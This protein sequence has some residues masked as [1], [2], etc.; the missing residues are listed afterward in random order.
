MKNKIK[1]QK[2]ETDLGQV[3]KSNFIIPEGC[4]KLASLRSFAKKNVNYNFKNII[5]IISDKTTLI[6]AYELIKSN[7]GNSTRGVAKNTLD[8]ISSEWFENTSKALLAGKY[9]FN[10]SRRKLITKPND[11]SSKRPL[12][13]A[14]PREKVV[15]KAVQMVLEAI[16]EPTFL[17]ESHGFRPN[18]GNHTALYHIK[19]QFKSVNWVIEADISKCFDTINHNK[20][21]DVIKERIS[22]DKTIALIKSAL[23]AGFIEGKQFSETT[24]GIPQGSI[25]SPILC[26]IFLHQLDRFIAK[27]SQEFDEGG[28]K[29]PR[30]NEKRRLKYQLD[31]TAKPKE[32]KKY[33]KQLMELKSSL[34]SNYKK[35]KYVR[36]ADDF[37]V[38]I[39]GKY[40]DANNMREE[41]NKYLEDISLTLN[42]QKTKITKFSSN[43]VFFLETF[44]RGTYRKNKPM[45]TISRGNSK[46]KTQITPQVSFH[47]PI[48]KLLGKLTEKGYFKRKG[49]RTVPKNFGAL[50][51]LNHSDILNRYNQIIK[52]ILNYYSFVDNFKSIG[53][54]IHRLKMSCALTLALKYKVRT[55]AKIFKKFGKKLGD[56]QTEIEL[57]IPKT[58]KR[59]Q[60]FKIN[61]VNPEK[62]IIRKWNN[63]LTNSNL[64]KACIICDDKKN[65][66]MRH[67]K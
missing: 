63:K 33:I 47:A 11:P 3:N 19:T 55:A 10:P 12:D 57:F 53:T 16:F 52:G 15:Q 31:K 61:Q 56:K 48:K 51:N 8:G 2:R 65:V 18:R 13:I 36:Y 32:R 1:I 7:P 5:H 14:N 21:L 62:I 67:V 45:K 38:G 66:E 44:I 49:N 58:F 40:I 22:C 43:K 50:V 30:N 24:L 35:L 34:N 46:F 6:L 54:I 59:S 4:E 9:K 42:L 28:T 25:I 17:N 64:G 20:L 23:K 29:R 39:A 26:N 27:K 41:M 37:L 60:I